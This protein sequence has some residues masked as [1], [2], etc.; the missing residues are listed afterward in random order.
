MG[1]MV[2]IVLSFVFHA[3]YC[4]YLYFCNMCSWFLLYVL[5]LLSYVFHGHI[6]LSVIIVCIC[7]F[8][9]CVLVFLSCERLSV[10]LLYVFQGFWN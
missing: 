3:F 7:L 1:F 4:V 6:R 8:I 5:V 10:L 2:S 9:I